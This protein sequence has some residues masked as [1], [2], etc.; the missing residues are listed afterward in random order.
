MSQAEDT[1]DATW[2]RA[3]SD[4]AFS[5]AAISAATSSRRRVEDEAHH[6]VRA[7]VLRAL[8]WIET[9]RSA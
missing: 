9:K 6:A 2:V 5:R 1:I 8:Q 7:A 4:V 3:A